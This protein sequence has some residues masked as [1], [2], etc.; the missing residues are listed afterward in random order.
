MLELFVVPYLIEMALRPGCLADVFA[1][2]VDGLLQIGQGLVGFAQVAVDGG[3]AVV[4]PGIARVGG[5]DVLEIRQGLVLLAV[6]L[7]G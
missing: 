6:N 2:Q 4:T 5:D 1:A 7:I 3:D